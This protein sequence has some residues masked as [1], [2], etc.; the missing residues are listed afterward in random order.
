MSEQNDSRKAH[1]PLQVV[2][3]NITVEVPSKHLLTAIVPG[4]VATL[5]ET[6]ISSQQLGLFDSQ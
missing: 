2:H 3:A 1:I 5:Q 6:D 4:L